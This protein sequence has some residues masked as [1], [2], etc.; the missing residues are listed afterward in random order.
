MPKAY[1]VPRLQFELD[2]YDAAIQHDSHSD[3]E[4]PRIK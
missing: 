4:I 2:W 3:T 1:V